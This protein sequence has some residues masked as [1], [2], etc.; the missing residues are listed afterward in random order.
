MMPRAPARYVEDRGLYAVLDDGPDLKE[1]EGA[2]QPLVSTAAPP[3]SDPPV[4][5]D[6]NKFGIRRIYKQ[7]PLRIPDLHVNHDMLFALTAEQAV[8]RASRTVKQII[9]PYPNI[10]SWRWNHH[11]WTLGDTRSIKSRSNQQLL[12]QASD[13][14]AADYAAANFPA[15]EAKVIATKT[16]PWDNPEDGWQKV[17][18]V[19]GVPVGVPRTQPEIRDARNRASRV[20]RNDP[21]VARAPA[22]TVE[23]QPYTVEG[24]YMRSLTGVIKNVWERDPLSRQFHTH[25]YEARG[26]RPDLEHAASSAPSLEQQERVLS[27]IYDSPEFLR[28]EAEARTKLGPT[29]KLPIVIIAMMIWSDATHLAQFGSA[30]LWPVYLYFG[31]LS[32]YIRTRRSAKAAYHVAYLPSVSA[33]CLCPSHLCSSS[34]LPDKVQEWIRA[35]TKNGKIPSDLPAHLARELFQAGLSRLFDGDFVHAYEHGM[36]LTLLDGIEILG[37]PRL[38]SWSADTPEK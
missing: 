16:H 23:G 18:L 21:D 12:A 24:A 26:P 4:A 22:P 6:A 17:D 7:R 19:I 38:F 10:T 28:L 20:R 15:I 5:T 31:N 1:E 27:E 36:A 9:A 14:V 29:T 13:F 11:F 2:V 34:Q 32:K 33:P 8:A 25:G 35:R 37:V 3:A 30:K